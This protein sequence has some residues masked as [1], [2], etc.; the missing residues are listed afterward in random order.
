MN[1]NQNA[2]K[3][4]QIEDDNLKLLR[5]LAEVELELKK[6]KIWK[7][8]MMMK[9][10]REELRNK[11]KKKMLMLLLVAA[12]CLMYTCIVLVTRVFV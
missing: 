7:K 2:M 5:K 1:Q 8:K 3:R 12:C 4:S 10:H 11:D 9:K 6:V